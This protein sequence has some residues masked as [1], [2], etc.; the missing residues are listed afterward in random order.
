LL[1]AAQLLASDSTPDVVTIDMPIA[2]VPIRGRREADRRI[3]AEFGGLGCGTH[4]PST[5]R[6]GEVGRALS[7]GFAAAGFPIAT[8]ATGPIVPALVE[9]Y[10][11]PAL[12]SLANAKYR[13]PYKVGK[14][15][16]YWPDLSPAERRK[17][18]VRKWRAIGRVL[19]R[20]IADVDLPL[21]TVAEAA[22][23]PFSQLKRFEDA[24]DALVCAWVGIQ[25]LDGGCHGY[26]D[27]TAAIW[28][29]VVPWNAQRPT[30]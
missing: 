15:G 2:T 6:P 21:P 5:A 26:G 10:P 4:T 13:V 16:T 20:T 11:H 25:Y 18:L 23:L 14:R 17:R 29:P 28:T 27:H 7:R 19:D 3:S 12:L 22:D 30:A 1:D 8:A 9:V 24:L